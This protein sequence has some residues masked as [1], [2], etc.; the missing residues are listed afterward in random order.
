MSEI[1]QITLRTT[2]RAFIQLM[3]I[4]PGAALWVRMNRAASVRS[5]AAVES[6]LYGSGSYGSDKY[7]EPNR[8]H[9]PIILRD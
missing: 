7:G 2:R 5:E 3:V 1:T 9:L 4:L 8:L 6:R